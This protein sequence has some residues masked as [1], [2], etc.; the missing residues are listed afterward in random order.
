[1]RRLL[2]RLVAQAAPGELGFGAPVP[3]FAAAGC[4]ARSAIGTPVVYLPF[5]FGSFDGPSE[6]HWPR[7]RPIADSTHR[8]GLVRRDLGRAR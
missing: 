8:F 7:E 3:G 6:F 5:I 1:M 4:D 2:A